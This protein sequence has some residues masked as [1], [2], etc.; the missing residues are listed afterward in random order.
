MI[1]F[2]AALALSAVQSVAVDG[3]A[4][5]RSLIAQSNQ[6]IKQEI[7]SRIPADKVSLSDQ[8]RSTIRIGVASACDRYNGEIAKFTSDYRSGAKTPAQVTEDML[9]TSLQIADAMA[10]MRVKSNAEGLK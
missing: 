4:Q 6:C 2:L 1:Y 9:V 3:E 8:E 7:D 5:L 10:V